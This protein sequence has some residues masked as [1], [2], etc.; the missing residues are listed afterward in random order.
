MA[1]SQAVRTRFSRGAPLLSSSAFAARIRGSAASFGFVPA[2]P[3]P[4]R[5]R[6]LRQ[7]CYESGLDGYKKTPE[8]MLNAWAT[9]RA[10]VTGYHHKGPM[11]PPS[12]S[13]SAEDLYHEGLD[14]LAAGDAVGA[15]QK[16]RDCL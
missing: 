7:E 9:E 16:L 6:P 14:R 1:K 13:S 2:G 11:A 8:K 4:T 5:I 3:Q 10:G 15:A 12:H